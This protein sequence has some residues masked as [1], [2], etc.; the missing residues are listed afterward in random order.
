MYDFLLEILSGEIPARMQYEAATKFAQMFEQTLKEHNLAF[1]EINALV[2]PRRLG[3]N[4]KNI[5][6]SEL[7]L[8]SQEIRGPKTNA[9]NNAIN[10][11]I[12]KN[13]LS[14][15]QIF[16]K[17]GHYFAKVKQTDYSV[18]DI[19]KNITLSCIKSLVWPKS[20]ILNS[21]KL[22]W[23]RPIE[24]ILCIVNGKI[25]DFNCSNLSSNNHTKGNRFMANV[26][27]EVSDFEDYKA[28]LRENYVII[29]PQERKEIILGQISSILQDKNLAL[30]E[31]VKLLNEIVGLTEYPQVFMDCIDQKFMDLPSE[32]LI[33]TLKH[34][35][36]YLMTRDSKDKLS[37]FYFIV[38]NIKPKDNG[39]TL[40]EGNQRVLNARLN[41][42]MFFYEQ[43]LKCN[44]QDYQIKLK[45]LM[46]NNICS[47]YEKQQKVT[48]LAIKFAKHLG[49]NEKDVI[50]AATLAKCDLASS[51]V[52]EF[53][54]LQGVAGYYYA[55]AQGEHI[56]VANAIRDHYK[57]QGPND[58][59]P[60][61][62]IG[63][64]LA[65]ADKLNSLQLL[66][67][68]G[69]RPSGSKDPLGLRRSAIGILR[70]LSEYNINLDLAQFDI[71]YDV[72]KFI[73]E[74]KGV[75]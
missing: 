7:E 70:I 28:K 27:F 33:T 49:A 53:P 73:D 63:I 2:T 64:A 75:N 1:L 16:E 67:G 5:T 69:I 12:R 60:I 72:R 3:I 37:P 48:D 38:A 18:K 74:R 24:N 42:A 11:F 6:K 21:E 25:L 44:L 13:N 40:I 71:D 8:S 41:D 15:D 29:A 32:I 46:Y 31:D 34:N 43:D 9:D 10:G 19:I 61:G 20:M 57:P 23:V 47:V 56:D 45:S 39:E 51:V 35:Q 17:N 68:S 36:R 52:K 4:I 59:L 54:E 30:I 62:P 66:F 65:L 14:Q 55:L 22:S 50:R 26:S 58:S